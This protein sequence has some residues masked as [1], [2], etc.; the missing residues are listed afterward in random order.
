MAECVFCGQKAAFGKT[1]TVGDMIFKACA[2]CYDR[3]SGQDDKIIVD[4]VKAARIF[5][6]GVKLKEWYDNRNEELKKDAELLRTEI[7]DHE[8]KLQEEAVGICP[9]CGGPM[10]GKGEHSLMTYVG[11]LPTLNRSAWNTGE[12]N[13][14]IIVCQQ[15]GY[16]EF[17]SKAGNS[18]GKL[19][20]KR[21]RLKTILEELGE[22]Q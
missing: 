8:R 15:C 20:K 5:D 11:G 19:E 18:I 13:V 7:D 3:Y 17:Y 2:D 1:I 14:R 10:L 12:F 22:D 6:D 4:A 21:E 9:K 16:T